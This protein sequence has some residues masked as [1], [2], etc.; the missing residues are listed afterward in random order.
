MQDIHIITTLGFIPRLNAISSKLSA[1]EYKAAEYIKLHKDDIIHLSIG[2]VAD[3]SHASEASFVRLCKRLGYK[4]FQ[5]LK[6]SLA[7]ELVGGPNQIHEAIGE[8]D[9]I[10]SIKKKIFQ[11][12]IQALYDSMEVC[13]DDALE[14]AIQAIRTARY[15]ELYGNGASGA[16]AIDAQ[17][18]FLKLGIKSFAYSDVFLQSMSASVLTEQDVVIA[19]S[20]SGANKDVIHAVKLAKDQ[21][22][23]II[24][25]TSFS[26][27][28]L[29][30]LSNIH[31]YTAANETKFRTDAIASRI[32]Q[33]A[34]IDTLFAGLAN[35]DYETNLQ[36]IEKIRNSTINRKF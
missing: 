30:K 3:R 36:N 29:T 6:I 15:L 17:H 14:K 5:H 7:K 9:N 8:E 35:I 18:K 16:V 32:A 1:A 13:G 20:H 2:E 12:S 19:I 24:A 28:P 11:A 22:A 4:G 26:K 23:V 25:I 33:L 31:L 34:I 21:G 10:A 27:S